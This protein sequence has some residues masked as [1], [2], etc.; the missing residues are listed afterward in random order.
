MRL[1]RM[2]NTDPFGATYGLPIRKLETLAYG[3]GNS[4]MYCT[5][6]VVLGLIGGVS[7]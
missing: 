2:P 5:G 7:R 6:H 3:F 1:S 4:W